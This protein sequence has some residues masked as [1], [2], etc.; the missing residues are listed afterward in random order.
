MLLAT[1]AVALVA[2]LFGL[3]VF[4]A[5]RNVFASFGAVLLAGC[6]LMVAFPSVAHRL[7]GEGLAAERDRTLRCDIVTFAVTSAICVGFFALAPR[8]GP[9]PCGGPVDSLFQHCVTAPESGALA[10]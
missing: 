8:Q 10:R 5:S 4:V 3:V 9:H 6:A 7:A 2:A 1:R